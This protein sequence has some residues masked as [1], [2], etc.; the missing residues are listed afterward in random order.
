MPMLET[1]EF[2]PIIRVS[3]TMKEEDGVSQDLCWSRI[4]R[5]MA[6]QLVVAFVVRDL[7]G[8]LTSRRSQEAVQSSYA[9]RILP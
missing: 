6:E 2:R 4:G 3:R 8:G 5:S 1:P 7:V 9:K